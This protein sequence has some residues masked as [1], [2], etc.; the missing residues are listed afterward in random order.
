MKT[1]KELPKVSTDLKL[2]DG[3]DTPFLLFR[4]RACV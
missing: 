4:Y 1:Q 3:T 2:K